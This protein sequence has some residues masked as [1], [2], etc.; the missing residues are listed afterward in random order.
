[1][2]AEKYIA[3]IE[4]GTSKIIGIVGQKNEDGTLQVLAIEREESSGCIKRG[5]IQNVEEA[6][7]RV[8]KI[9]T[10]LGNRVPGSI[11][12]MYVGVGGQ[13]VRTIS[14]KV[15]RRLAED[16]PVTEVLINSLHAESRTFPVFNAEI[17]DVVPNEYLID[18]HLETNPVGTFCYS[19]AAK[20]K[21]P[22]TSSLHKPQQQHCLPVM[23]KAWAAH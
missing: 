18:N 20:C 19:N 14:H 22:A 9:I 11:N 3:A 10:K 7:N 8:K 13:S 4:L 12:K 15:R 21:L 6:A 1:M 16:T 23:K 17:M 2:D 5:C